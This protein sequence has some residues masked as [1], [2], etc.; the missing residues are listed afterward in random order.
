MILMIVLYVVVGF[1]ILCI[2]S[3]SEPSNDII[4]YEDPHYSA[5]SKHNKSN[6]SEKRNTNTIEVIRAESIR[7][8]DYVRK[9]GG[10]Y[11]Y[12]NRVTFIQEIGVDK[13]NIG[14]G[15]GEGELV[16]IYEEFQRKL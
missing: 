7:E 5:T 13:L 6:Q 11:L 2:K 15:P 1:I 16:F 9:I 4:R 8:D 10:V 3:N 14:Y 12:F